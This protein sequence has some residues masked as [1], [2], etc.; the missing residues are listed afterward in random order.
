MRKSPFQVF[1]NNVSMV[2][3]I[4]TDFTRWPIDGFHISLIYSSCFFFVKLSS[5]TEQ[6]ERNGPLL[7]TQLKIDSNTLPLLN[8]WKVWHWSKIFS[9]R[10]KLIY[11]QD[12]T[13]KGSEKL[14]VK[15][16]KNTLKIDKYKIRRFIKR[17]NRR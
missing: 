3:R 1:F 6:R 8:P 2:K 9:T 16:V 4:F 10:Y 12:F 13:K 7:K 11:I 17:Q 14:E 5:L 15:F